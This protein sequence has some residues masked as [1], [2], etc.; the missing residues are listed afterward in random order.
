M[1]KKYKL[2][3]KYT[4]SLFSIILIIMVFLL[5]LSTGYA[6]WGSKL[7]ISGKAVAEKQVPDNPELEIAVV[8]HN[9]AYTSVEGSSEDIVL[10]S[11]SLTENLLKST[12]KIDEEEGLIPLNI[13]FQIKNNSTEEIYTDGKITDVEVSYP[14]GSIS[15]YFRSISNSQIS[16][17]E[18]SKFNYSAMIDTEKFTAEGKY[19]FE[20]SFDVNG[21]TKYFYYELRILPN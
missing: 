8:S 15:N 4:I 2:K 6:L 20:I 19:R 21:T 1:G 5:L 11:E 3:K 16:Y 10:V 12:L 18:I 17:G 7:H 9:G 14:S 13:S